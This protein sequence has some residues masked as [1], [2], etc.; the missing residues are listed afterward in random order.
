MYFFRTVYD[1]PESIRGKY[2]LTD[3]RNCAHGSG[4]HLQIIATY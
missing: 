1:E 3:T 4:N 2:G